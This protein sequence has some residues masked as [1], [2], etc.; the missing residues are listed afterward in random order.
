MFCVVCYAQQRRGA[1]TAWGHFQEAQQH[2]RAQ[3]FDAAHASLTACKRSHD[4]DDFDIKHGVETNLGRLLGF[5]IWP[6]SEEHERRNHKTAVKHFKAAA[7]LK[8]DL[9]EAHLSL[10]ELHLRRREFDAATPS[11]KR[12][13]RLAPSRAISMYEHKLLWDIEERRQSTGARKEEARRAWLEV[14]DLAQ[15][16]PTNVGR[17]VQRW[18]GDV[19]AMPPP[20]P[21]SLFEATRT[22]PRPTPSEW[23][24]APWGERASPCQALERHAG[25][26]IGDVLGAA[27]PSRP[28]VISGGEERWPE[29]PPMVALDAALA[30]CASDD[31][32]VVQIFY[33]VGGGGN[34]MQLQRAAAWADRAP[35]LRRGSNGEGDGEGGDGGGIGDGPPETVLVRGP[36]EFLTLRDLVSLEGRTRVAMYAG[37]TNLD[38]Y[39]P[40]LM[41][42]VAAA[43]RARAAPAATETTGQSGVL[44]ARIELPLRVGGGADAAAGAAAASSSLL[45]LT[46][47]EANLWLGLGGTVSGL[48]FDA[49]TNLHRVYAGTK[50][51]LLFPPGP[52]TDAALEMVPTVEIKPRRHPPAETTADASSSLSSSSSSSSSSSTSSSSSSAS[53]SSS[54]SWAVETMQTID[55]FPRADCARPGE[56][57]RRAPAAVRCV[58]RAGDVLYV[59]RGWYHN[60]ISTPDGAAAASATVTAA[61]AAVTARGG[62]R[63]TDGDGASGGDDGADGVAEAEGDEALSSS[64]SCRSVG[65]N[66]WYATDGDDADERPLNTPGDAPR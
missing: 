17:Q 10:A 21:P 65:L 2:L 47:R 32:N 27:D 41:E 16:L 18:R 22:C 42:H 51:A 12:A 5:D 50:D 33:S 62:V 44:P 1:S 8:P 31:R 29:F 38:V 64:P 4:Y 35:E 46:L 6:T 13:M 49:F 40:C 23:S 11:L 26:S 55:N 56:R 48:H 57:A 14:L 24:T 45:N 37:N 39:L 61:T 54:S 59:P 52:Q 3:R 9:L 20:T 30:S 66:L 25:Q 43:A 19:R 34:V 58:A 60:V 36:Q 53:S 7:K 63:G 28:A 15:R